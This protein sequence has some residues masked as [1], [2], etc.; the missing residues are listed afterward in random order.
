MIIEQTTNEHDI[1]F[2]LS[3]P[4][5]KKHLF[6]D[7]TP[8]LDDYT[9]NPEHIFLIGRVDDEIAAMMV[10]EPLNEVSLWCHP[11]VIPR[12]RSRY[13]RK[14]VAEALNWAWDRDYIKIC[15][16]IPTIYPEVINFA[17]HMGFM[18][19]GLSKKAHLQDNELID[20]VYLGISNPRLQ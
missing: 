4:E 3:D 9:P 19:E 7:C 11:Q 13:A 15:A 17:E 16:H 2:V 1:K 12:Y 8:D 14:F 18:R 10:Y 6:A 20:L 5:I